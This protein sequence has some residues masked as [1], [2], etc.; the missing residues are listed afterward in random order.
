[1]KGPRPRG[2]S[3]RHG[4][5]NWVLKV[6]ESADASRPMKTREIRTKVAKLSGKRIPDHSLYQALRTLVARKVVRTIRIGRE[7]S[8]QLISRA[9]SVSARETGHSLPR[10]KGA[11]TSPTATQ[12]LHKLAPGEVL[13]LEIWTGHVETATNRRGRLVLERH[14][15]PT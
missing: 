13:I 15:R 3:A 12:A 1:M 6:L 14:P 8:F 2:K 10:D 11:A 9:Q 7:R 4:T 5:R